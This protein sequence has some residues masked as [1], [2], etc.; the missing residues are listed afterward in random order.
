[1]VNPANDPPTI[2]SA[3]ITTDEDTPSAGVTPVVTDPDTDD[4]H[5]FTIV[6]QP[7]NGSASV[8]GN[9]LVYTPSPEFSGTDSFAFRATDSGV[10]SV[11]GTATVTVNA[12]NDASVAENDAYSVNEGETLTT[13]AITGVLAN[14]S[15]AEN[16]PLTAVLV[17]DVFHGTLSLNSDGSFTYTHDGSETTTD[18]FTYQA[19]DGAAG[20]LLAIVTITVNPVNDAPTSTSASITT[21]EETQNAGVRPAVTDADVGDSHTFTI[22]TQPTN[23]TASVVANQL[24]YTPNAD[25]NGTDSFTYRATDSGALFVDGTASVTV[26]AV[27]DAPVA[28][29]DSY[30]VN[31][32]TTLNITAPGVLANDNDIEG[33][34]LTAVLG[35][36]SSKGTLTLNANGSFIYAPSVDFNGTDTFTYQVNDGTADSNPVTV[37]ITV[38]PVNDA[39]VATDDIYAVDEGASLTAAT[40]V[41]ANDSDVD[42]DGLTAMLVSD[43]SHGTL[44]FNGDGFFTYEHSG[45]ETSVDSLVYEVSDGNGGTAES[46]VTIVVNPANDPPTITSASITTDEDTPSSGV[47]PVVTDPDTDDSHTF[48]IVTGPANGSASVVANQLVYTPNAEFSGIDSF[49]FRATDSGGLSVDGTAT[50]TVN[51]VNDAPVAEN[52]AYSVNEGETLITDP[53]NGVLADDSDAENDALTAFLV[54]DVSHGTLIFNSDG[55]FTYTH[56]G[57]ETTTDSFTYQAIDGAAGSDIATVNITINQ[58]PPA[59]L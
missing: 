45:S 48:T 12:V 24:V 58:L 54:S 7:A 44:T 18:S 10:L 8:V 28:N 5:T 1:V 50:V 29:G 9:K 37:T 35:N 23:G 39:P 13:E 22:F 19:I 4:S 11:D 56:D 3:S 14:D 53:T 2:T 46:T 30:A 21:D 38:N 41:L 47:T 17:S 49:T 20:S 32:D 15:D 59:C 31:E 36:N 55:S 16:D 27:N 52:D 33:D 57:S 34:A 42:G 43:V 25:F 51:A 26:N 6:T 40:G